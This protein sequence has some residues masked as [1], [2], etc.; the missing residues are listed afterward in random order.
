MRAVALQDNLSKVKAVQDVYQQMLRF[1]DDVQHA[2]AGELQKQRHLRRRQVNRSEKSDGGKLRP[3]KDSPEAA[4]TRARGRKEEP[5]SYPPEEE[6][7]RQCCIDFR[8]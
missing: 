5:A 2:L 3:R 4:G 1:P 6:A 7:G 8:A